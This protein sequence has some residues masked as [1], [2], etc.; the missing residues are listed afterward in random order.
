MN[1]D[2]FFAVN[3]IRHITTKDAT[4]T[5]LIVTIHGHRIYSTGLH[6]YA[7]T[8]HIIP[9][10]N[11]ARNPT[12]IWYIVNHTVPAKSG[13]FHIVN[14][15][16]STCTGVTNNIGESIFNAAVSHKI[17]ASITASTLYITFSIFLLIFII[18]IIFRHTATN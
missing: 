5:A 3:H 6:I 12:T 9:H 7:S 15:L 4:G 14:N 16:P 18:E 11:P 8:A 10:N 13:S 17:S 2:R 1:T